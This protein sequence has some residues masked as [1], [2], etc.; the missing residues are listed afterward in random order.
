MNLADDDK[1]RDFCFEV[2]EK[3]YKITGSIGAGGRYDKLMKNM[4]GMDTPAVGFASGVERLMLLFEN[5][6]TEDR[7]VAIIPI[8]ENE[9]NYCLTLKNTLLLN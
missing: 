4:G 7:P 9:V 6:F 5:N 2:Y 3:N 8:R 1:V